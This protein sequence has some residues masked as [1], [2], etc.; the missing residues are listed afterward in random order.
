[1]SPARLLTVRELAEFLSVPERTVHRMALAGEVPGFR[2]R[3]AWRFD[4]ARVL[5]ALETTGGGDRRTQNGAAA[6]APPDS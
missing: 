4:L 1:M 5:I 3:R 2:V 6:T